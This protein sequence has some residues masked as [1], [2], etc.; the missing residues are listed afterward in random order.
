MRLIRRDSCAPLFAFALALSP[1]ASAAQPS[2]DGVIAERMPCRSDIGTRAEYLAFVMSPGDPLD[3]VPDRGAV[4]RFVTPQRF[5]RVREV[6]CE[7]ISYWS[8]GLLVKGM[9]LGPRPAAEAPTPVVLF[10]RGG[11]AEWGRITLWNR[12]SLLD[13]VDRGYLVLATEYRGNHGGDGRDELGGAD[14]RDVSALAAAAR[15]EGGSD[16]IFVLGL[17]RGGQEALLALAA[18]LPARA[19]AVVGAATDARTALL[20]RPDL[21]DVYRA[22]LPGFDA[23][24][25]ELLRLRSPIEFV[26]RLAAPLFLLHGGADRRVARAHTD[27][28]ARALGEIGRPPRVFIAEGDDHGLTAHWPEAL[29]RIADFFDEHR[30][31]LSPP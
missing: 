14:V 21:L 17:S 30:R 23:S 25:D 31:P 28:L 27:S 20:D 16:Q 24:R 19:V 4:E 29:S 22:Q 15:Q 5:A 8:D 3:P 18:G 2:A 13:F 26:S 7:R 12:L 6:D 11:A 10:L 1:R 9:R